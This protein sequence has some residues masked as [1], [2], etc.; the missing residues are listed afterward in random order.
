[1]R[2]LSRSLLQALP[3]SVQDGLRRMQSDLY[4]RRFRAAASL[5]VSATNPDAPVEV[6]TLLCHRDVWPYLYAIK[7]L[8]LYCDDV[9]VVLHDDGTLSSSDVVLL[10]SQLP[11]IRIID[12]AS[13]DA[14][15]MP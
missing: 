8:L 1:M 13:A 10:R 12:T 6:H 15:V 2:L 3:P 4:R 9:S 5:P 14:A 11:G 7:S